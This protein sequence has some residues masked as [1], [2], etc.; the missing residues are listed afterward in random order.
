MSYKKHKY[1]ICQ[2]CGEKGIMLNPV[3]ILSLV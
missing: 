3:E 2:N 1:L